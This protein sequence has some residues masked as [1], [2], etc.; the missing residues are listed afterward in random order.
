MVNMYKG[1]KGKKDELTLGV[2]SKAVEGSPSRIA[3]R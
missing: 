3:T 1:A 2:P